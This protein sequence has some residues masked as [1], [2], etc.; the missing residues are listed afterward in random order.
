MFHDG[1]GL[2]LQ[3]SNGGTKSWVL[4][5]MLNGRAREMGLGPFHTISLADARK[6]AADC[7]RMKLDGID[8]IE[9]RKEQ[10]ASARLAAANAMTF[11]SCAEAYIEAHKAGW[12]N[13]KHAQQ[14]RNTL[15]TY[16]YPVFGAASVQSVDTDMV[17]RVLE[18][19]WKQ[20]TETA[21]RIRGRIERVLDWAKARRHRTGENPALWRGHLDQ[22]LPKRSKV[23]KVRH[24]P[25]LPYKQVGTF[26]AELRQQAGIAASALELLVLTAK[27]TSEIIGAHWNEVDLDDA[28]WTIPAGRIKGGREHR[29]PLSRAA[30]KVLKRIRREQQQAGYQGDFVFPGAKAGKHLSDMAMLELRLRMGYGHV[31][32][33]GFRS[34]CKDWAAECTHYPNEVSEMALAH[35]VSDKVEAAYRR[36]DLFAKRRHMMEDWAKY[37]GAIETGTLTMSRRK[38]A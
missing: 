14:W 27:R 11:K 36:G 37:C 5:Y 34:T 8:P 32:V 35:V 22:L 19:I 6:K 7:R 2:Y 28:M 21:S 24:H 26:M 29:I 20:K 12:K 3:V 23:R 17:M 38:A 18:P 13:A 25:A 33:H 9:A 4:R 10:R 30:V 1:G 16:V 15:T 31:T